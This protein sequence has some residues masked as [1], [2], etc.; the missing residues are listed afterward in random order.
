LQLRLDQQQQ[1]NQPFNNSPVHNVDRVSRDV[2]A[3]KKGPSGSSISFR[4]ARPVK[5]F[6]EPQQANS[7]LVRPSH[8]AEFAMAPFAAGRSKVPARTTR[9]ESRS[10]AANGFDPSV[11][12]FE[13][14]E[15]VSGIV[16]KM[17]DGEES[18]DIRKKDIH[19]KPYTILHS[20]N[21]IAAWSTRR[22]PNSVYFDPIMTKSRP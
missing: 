13:R 21:L 17:E 3:Q 20:V 19:L 14:A 6:G 11:A 16:N 4:S 15:V 5:D 2:E 18:G 7:L 12:H 8:R 1:T 10:H 22:E 9:Q